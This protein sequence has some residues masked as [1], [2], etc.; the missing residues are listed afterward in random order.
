[1]KLIYAFGF[2]ILLFIS[3]K[4]SV[5]SEA[6]SIRYKANGALVQIAGERDT[7]GR[8]II[9]GAYYGCFVTKPGGSGFYTV[10]GSDKVHEVLIAI[11]T[12]K[13]SLL[14]TTYSSDLLDVSFTINDTAYGINNGD[15]MTL[16]ISRYS[17]ATIDATFS[18][19]VSDSHGNKKAITEGRLNNL[20]VY[21]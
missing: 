9:T 8:D 21:Y 3:C 19:T 18:G 12:S 20:K 6:S 13:D 7:S 17:N 10:Y 2:C 15:Q 1:M 16:N 14:E 4:K 11:A 5:T